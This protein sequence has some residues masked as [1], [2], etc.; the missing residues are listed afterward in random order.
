MNP[1]G[2]WDNWRGSNRHGKTEP[3]GILYEC[4]DEYTSDGDAAIEALRCMYDKLSDAG[5]ACYK[6]G[7]YVN[8]DYIDQLDA[9]SRWHAELCW[10]ILH[11]IALHDSRYKMTKRAE[12]GPVLGRIERDL[13]TGQL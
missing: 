8:M 3:L 2:Y 5:E 1:D 10:R 12:V 7:L 4:D 11:L 9:V 13:R 6:A